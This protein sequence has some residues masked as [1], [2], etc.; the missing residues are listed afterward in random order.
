MDF[1]PFLEKED[2]ACRPAL[3]LRDEELKQIPSLRLWGR[4]AYIPLVDKALELAALGYKVFPLAPSEKKPLAGSRGAN[5]G[6][7]EQQTHSEGAGRP[8]GACFVLKSC[9]QAS[10][11]N[12]V[13]M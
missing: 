5:E 10:S 1:E 6:Y 13:D 12:F 4:H 2:Q 11:S 3:P 7:W 8:A 9:D